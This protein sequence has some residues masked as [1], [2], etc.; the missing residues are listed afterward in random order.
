MENV[1]RRIDCRVTMP[2][3]DWLNISGEELVKKTFGTLVIMVLE[4][5]E[6]IMMTTVRR[7]DLSAKI[8]G[9]S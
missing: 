3:W 8:N 2:Y 6:G 5:I 1:L 4:E 9:V 7:T